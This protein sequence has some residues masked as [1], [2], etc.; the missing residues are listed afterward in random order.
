MMMTTKYLEVTTSKALAVISFIPVF[1]EPCKDHH[2]HHHGHH[3]QDD[4]QDGDQ[5]NHLPL[6]GAPG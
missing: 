6:D 1:V 5:P 4:H 3:H 2:R